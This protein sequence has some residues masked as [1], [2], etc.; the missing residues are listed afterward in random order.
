MSGKKK[1]GRARVTCLGCGSR[2][3]G[4][5]VAC[6]KCGQARMAGKSAGPAFIGKSAGGNVVPLLTKSA[7]PPTWPCPGCRHQLGRSATSCPRCGRAGGP[8][9]LKSAGQVS[10]FLAKNASPIA[11]RCGSCFQMQPPGSRHCSGCGDLMP[12]AR[13]LLGKGAASVR[14]SDDFWR[15][16]N[17]AN[18]ELLWRIMHGQDTGGAA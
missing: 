7:M 18:R 3:K 2:M 5:D 6:R 1:K 15:E 11:G 8:G 13:P 14:Y 9:A 4:A 10:R 16:S 12:G 17:P